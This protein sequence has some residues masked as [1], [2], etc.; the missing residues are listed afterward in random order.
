MNMRPGS[1]LILLG[2]MCLT[3][4][5][6][7]SIEQEPAEEFAA[8]GLYKVTGTGFETAYIVPNANLPGYGEIQFEPFT[9]TNVDVTQ[10]TVTGTNRR[11]WQ[12]TPERQENLK[13]AWVNA[14]NHAFR[15]YPREEGAG[16]QLRIE[17]E[18]VRISPGRSMTTSPGSIGSSVSANREVVNVSVEFRLFDA[19]SKQLLALVRDRQTIGSQQWTRAA[20]VDMANLLN[21][22]AALLHTRVSGR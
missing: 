1:T 3:A 13:Q 10:T 21:S 6:T 5:S 2:L 22:W 9:S 20:G 7:P 12:M 16:Q 14:T 8:E 4:C 11:D 17:A 18:L 19:K 15:N